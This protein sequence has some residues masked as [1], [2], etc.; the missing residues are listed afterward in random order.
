VDAEGAPLEGAARATCACRQL[1]GQAR[2]VYGDHERFLQ[3]YFS[4]YPRA[5]TSR[6]TAAG[7]T[8]TAT[9]GSPGAWT[10]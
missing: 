3:T 4:T 8:P 6:A 9:T 10:T 1:A 5:A 2:T 7:A